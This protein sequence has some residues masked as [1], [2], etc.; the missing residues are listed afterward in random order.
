V[1]TQAHGSGRE[2]LLACE[3]IRLLWDYRSV[4]ALALA[5]TFLVSR[6]VLVL[7]CEPRSI[8]LAELPRRFPAGVA[9][10]S[11]PPL[12]P[13]LLCVA[14]FSLFLPNSSASR[15]VICP[16]Q[17]ADSIVVEQF[18]I[19]SDSVPQLPPFVS[20]SDRLHHRTALL[21]QNRSSTQTHRLSTSSP[22]IG[23]TISLSALVLSLTSAW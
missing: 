23:P 22:D 16:G 12:P 11:P 1:F 17:H 7:A 15:P 14:A 2:R 21:P 18:S 5:G 9:S 6:F 19:L 10:T 20:T 3:A 4:L 13:D 8:E